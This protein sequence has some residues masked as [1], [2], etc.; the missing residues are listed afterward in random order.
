MMLFVSMQPE[1]IPVFEPPAF[2]APSQVRS[3]PYTAEPYA[4][5]RIPDREAFDAKVTRFSPTHLLVTWQRAP[6]G[7]RLQAWVPLEWAERIDRSDSAWKDPH[8][9]GWSSR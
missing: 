3:T 4:R 6:H 9:L 8:C 5:V 7:E 2:T 1:P